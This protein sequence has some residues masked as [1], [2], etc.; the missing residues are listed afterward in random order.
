MNK[1]L[2]FVFC[3]VTASLVLTAQEKKYPFVTVSGNVFDITARRPIEAVAVL[4]SSGRG[5]ITDSLGR[6]SLVVKDNDSIWFSM[7][8]KTTMKYAVDTIKN[9]AEFNVSILI[10]AAEL[11]EVKVRNNYY[12]FDSLQNR[13]DYA[14]YFNFKKPGIRIVSSSPTYNTSPGVTAGFDL[15]AIINM[16]RFKYNKSMEALQK[17][18]IQQEQDKYIDHR[19]SKQFVRKITKLQSPELDTFMVRYRPEYNFLQTVNDLELGYYVEKCF[20]HYKANRPKF[21]GT[22]RKKDEDN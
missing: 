3:F 6:Y 16:F 18:L 20:D 1:H 13:Q 22:L 4:S 19:F 15:D 12:K 5:T 7:L 10:K 17:R 21:R 11:P 9:L 2:L 14:K 8:G